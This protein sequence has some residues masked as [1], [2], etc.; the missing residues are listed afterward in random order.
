[1]FTSDSLEYAIEVAQFKARQIA[2]K[3]PGLGDAQDIQQTLLED[4]LQRLPTFDDARAGVKTFICRLIDH[5]IAT[6]LESQ[7]AVRRG[8][9]RRPTSLD[10]R[11]D[12]ESGAWALCDASASGAFAG[13]DLALDV[14]A[15]MRTLAPPLR[16]LCERLRTR[17]PTE[18]AQETG[19]ARSVI[20]QRISALRDIFARAQ[21]LP[22]ENSAPLSGQRA[23]HS[24][25]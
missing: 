4:V 5:R 20:Y 15:I 23:E 16:D 10:N 11:N 9:G 13:Q 8:G 19:L 6:L 17:T 2:R 18:I 21:L 12:D 3:L 1:M 25:K 14:A 22:A 7:R 24:G